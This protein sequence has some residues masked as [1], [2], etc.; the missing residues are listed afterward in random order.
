MGHKTRRA[1]WRRNTHAD[2]AGLGVLPMDD[3]AILAAARAIGFPVLVKPAAAAAASACCR[4]RTNRSC[5]SR[6]AL[7]LD[8]G[9]RFRV[10]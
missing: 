8:G 3:A 6:G 2:V 10:H 7:A 9:A 5:W 4:R 1:N